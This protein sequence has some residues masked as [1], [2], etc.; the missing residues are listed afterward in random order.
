MH[1]LALQQSLGA[2]GLDRLHVVAR[3]SPIYGDRCAFRFVCGHNSNHFWSLL[4][5]RKSARWYPLTLPH[6]GVLLGWFVAIC[7]EMMQSYSVLETS[8]IRAQVEQRAVA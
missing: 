3:H 8:R 1:R 7:R 5:L 2:A 6:D 4:M